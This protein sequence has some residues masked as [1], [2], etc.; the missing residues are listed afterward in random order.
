MGLPKL[1]QNFQG[2]RCAYWGE[3]LLATLSCVHWVPGILQAPGKLS[4][5]VSS[6]DGWISLEFPCGEGQGQ[7]NVLGMGQM[8][9]P[10]WRR[11]Q[12]QPRC[13]SSC[14]WSLVRFPRT[15][16]AHKLLSQCSDEIGRTLGNAHGELLVMI[17]MRIMTIT[18]SLCW[19][20]AV[21][22]ML[23]NT[24]CVLS[25]VSLEQAFY[26]LCF[27]DEETGPR[28]VK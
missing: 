18:A 27:T 1:I 4:G 22:Q 8:K 19:M 17:M 14:L 10:L 28:E 11:S 2:D 25:P 23:C 20:S 7:V 5:F 16:V 9:M 12:L 3:G 24:W 21:C 6:V 26:G 15:I 13:P